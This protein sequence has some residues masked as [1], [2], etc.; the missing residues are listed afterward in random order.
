MPH[1][2]PTTFLGPGYGA[3][4]AR[5]VFTCVRTWSCRTTWGSESVND[6]AAP[7]RPTAPARIRL[8]G[9]WRASE[10]SFRGSAEGLHCFILRAPRMQGAPPP[11]R[12]LAFRR[13]RPTENSGHRNRNG[14]KRRAPDKYRDY[15]LTA[16][17]GTRLPRGKSQRTG[18]RGV[19]E[20]EKRR[21]ARL[22]A[23]RWRLRVA[24]KGFSHENQRTTGQQ[25]HGSERQRQ[26]RGPSQSTSV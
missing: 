15:G 16:P 18:S 6:P 12:I 5:C 10:G 26:R 9:S 23:L 21:N 22:G 13:P 7:S 17:I 24:R 11:P 4:D 14:C 1:Q 2:L 19:G 3:S 25:W 20:I 8:S